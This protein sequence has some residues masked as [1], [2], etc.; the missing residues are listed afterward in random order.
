MVKRAGTRGS[1]SEGGPPTLSDRHHILFNRQEWR[2][3]P[4]AQ[5]LREHPS[6]VPSLDRD[7]HEELHA[8]CPAVPLLGYNA[9]SKVAKNWYPQRDTL[10]SMDELMYAIGQ[11]AKHPLMH[12]IERDQAHLTIEAIHIQKPFVEAGLIVPRTQT[13]IDLGRAA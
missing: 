2:L 3:R 6:L 9:L 5:E 4:Q 10:R 7:V 1:S 13:I 11:A 12:D 8:A